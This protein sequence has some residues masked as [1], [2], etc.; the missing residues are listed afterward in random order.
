M[1][2]HRDGTVLTDPDGAGNVTVQAGILKTKVHISDLKLL[3]K[4]KV[5]M[6]TA[7]SVSRNVTS[8][9]E[10]N[11]DT[12]LDLRG[13]N[14]EEAIM[15]VERFIDNCVLSSM[16]TLTIIHG[17]GSGVLRKAVHACLKRNKC[18]RTFRLGVFGEG[19]SGVTIVELK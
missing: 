18:V 7:R 2:I 1:S 12:E 16:K 3:D 9:L 4:K 8:K 13:M 19:E 15:E 10:R 14:A 6:S 17:K 5:T 11:V